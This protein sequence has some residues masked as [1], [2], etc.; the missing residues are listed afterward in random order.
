MVLKEGTLPHPVLAKFATAIRDLAHDLLMLEAQGSY[1]GAQAM[2]A[3]YGTPPGPMVK[4][5]ASLKD[6]PVD[7]DPVFAADAKR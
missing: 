5:I 7:V 6:I 1:A 2:A 4:L 3:T